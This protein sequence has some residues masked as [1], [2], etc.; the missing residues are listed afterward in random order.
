[1]SGNHAAP[2]RSPLLLARALS[3]SLYARSWSDEPG[4]GA[5]AREA[6]SARAPGAGGHD[7]ALSDEQRSA[8]R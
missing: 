6:S 7:E 4:E 5:A 2:T 3:F 1:M 8:H